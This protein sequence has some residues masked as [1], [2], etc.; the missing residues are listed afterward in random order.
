MSLEALLLQFR[1]DRAFMRDVAAWERVP[2][3]PARYAAFPSTLDSRL[4]QALNARGI[5]Q[6]YTHQAAAVD[7]VARGQNPVVVTSTASGKTLCYNL[8][9]LNT[10]LHDRKANAL[11][12]FPTKALAHDQLV[13]LN[14]LIGDLGQPITVQAYDGDTSREKRKAARSAGGV[15]I[16]NPDML[17]TGILPHHTQWAAFFQSLRFIVVDELHTYRGIFGSHF[18]NVI[19][20]LKRICHFYGSQPQFILSSATIAN[21]QQ[22]AERLIEET[23]TLIDDDGAPR[24]EKHWILINPPLIDPAIGQRRSVILQSRD[25]A[26]RCLQADVQ[27]IVFA[28]ARLTTEVLL[29][30]LR[31]AIASDGGDPAKV[32]GY[33]GGYLA[34]ERRTIEKGLRDGSIRGVVSTNALELGVDIGQLDVAVLAGYPGTIASTLQQAGRAG[35]RSNISAALIV[36]SASPLDQFIVTHPRYFFERSPEHGL[37]APD[38]LIILTNHLK[39]ATFE[40]PF[41]AGEKFGRFQQTD[42]LLEAL[43][44]EGILHKQSAPK[45]ALPDRYFWMSDQYPANGLSLRTGTADTIV[46][47]DRSEGR[48]RSIGQIDRESAQTH[49]HAGA[50]YIHEGQSFLVEKLDWDNGQAFVTPAHVDYYTEASTSTNVDVENEEQREAAGA[51]IK[52]VGEVRVSWLTTGFRKIKLYTHETLGWGEIALPEQEMH[53]TAY[54]F[55]VEPALADR[56]ID[57]GV[58]FTPNDYGPDWDRIRSE[59]LERD[60]HRCRKCGAGE[61][62]G[63]SHDVHHL[64][65]FREFGYRR[66]VND[67]DKIANAPENLLTLCRACHHRVEAAVGVRGALSGLGHVLGEIAPLY[68]MCDPRDIGVLAETRSAFTELPTLTIFDRVPA[69]IGFSQELFDLHDQLLAS[70]REIVANCRCESGCP[71]CV[72][73]MSPAEATSESGLNVKV[74]TLKLLKALVQ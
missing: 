57:E 18:A 24:G 23:V 19:R 71:A 36:A 49:V 69:G 1:S 61:P 32:H 62:P 66:G 37:V 5:D 41:E 11:Y 44:E 33:R 8:P 65:P 25:L 46:I 58:I 31:E 55:C 54:W 74:L 68:L 48:G 38:N 35:R 16:T 63:R 10:L 50:I 42:E 17:H 15:L 70:A 59:I 39:C 34:E 20:R 30:Y 29:T 43:V 3:R 2:D 72:G 45:P 53:T 22:L 26:A 7:V 52:S 67:N 51:T 64:R 6:L 47:L 9:V 40:L 12:L 28:R 73:P 4:K 60:A 56:L 13:T 21:P 14:E 27:T